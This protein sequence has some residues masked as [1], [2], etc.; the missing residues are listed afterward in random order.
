M[1]V[2]TKSDVLSFYLVRNWI[3]LHDWEHKYVSKSFAL[4]LAEDGS[5]NIFLRQFFETTKLSLIN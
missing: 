1:E 5:C 2:G 4:K 3:F